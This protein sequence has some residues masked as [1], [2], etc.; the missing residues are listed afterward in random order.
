MLRDCD[1]L[2]YVFHSLTDETT[3]SPSTEKQLRHEGFKIMCQK[4]PPDRMAKLTKLRHVCDEQTLIVPLPAI[5]ELDPTVLD[6]VLEI[7]SF[8]FCAGHLKHGGLIQRPLYVVWHPDLDH[9]YVVVKYFLARNKDLCEVFKAIMS[10]LRGSYVEKYKALPVEQRPSDWRAILVE[11]ECEAHSWMKFMNDRLYEA[12]V[13][14][15][16][17]D[18]NVQR[19]STKP[20]KKDNWFIEQL[21]Q[22]GKKYTGHELEDTPSA[23]F[24]GL[25]FF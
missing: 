25:P 23:G 13:K 9:R 18:T 3:I 15:Q 21:R 17:E 10:V 12:L 14:L 1:D 20:E 8:Q 2:V 24:F 7:S 16:V 22:V 6:D 5:K 19:A 4:I 11:L